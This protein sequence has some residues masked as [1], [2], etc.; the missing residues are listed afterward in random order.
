MI[1]V[2]VRMHHIIVRLILGTGIGLAPSGRGLEA[3]GSARCNEKRK[4]TTNH[5]IR[6][7]FEGTWVGSGDETECIAVRSC[8]LLVSVMSSWR[9]FLRS[10]AIY[11][12]AAI[13]FLAKKYPFALAIGPALPIAHYG[14]KARSRSRLEAPV[15]RTIEEG[16]RPTCIPSVRTIDRPV[17]EQKLKRLIY[18]DPGTI[19]DLSGS[20]MFGIVIGPSGTGKTA[21]VR[22]MCNRDPKGILYFEVFDPLCFAQDLGT[23]VGMV[24][25]PTSP[26]DLLLMFISG[27]SY[28]QYH[29]I[30]RGDLGLQYVLAG[31]EQQ[32]L[33]Y[34]ARH[35]RTPVLVVDGVDLLAK[36]NKT[37][38][39]DLIDRAKFLANS[40]SLR[41]VLVSSE[42]S[43][44]P[45]VMETSSRSR[46]ADTVEVVDISKEE[47]L[48]FIS[49]S[50]PDK[51]ARR[52]EEL[53]GG[54][55][56][57][58]LL[59][60]AKYYELQEAGEKDIEVLFKSIRNHLLQSSV[61]LSLKS[62]LKQPDNERQLYKLI[63]KQVCTKG[64]VQAQ[65]IAREFDISTER[66]E[67]A[68]DRLVSSN[69]LRFTHGGDLACY[70]RL[71]NW[72]WE[73]DL[74]DLGLPN[75]KKSK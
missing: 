16:S 58:L 57:H 37:M 9:L 62:L 59:A 65:A 29:K 47:A 36:R 61:K 56:I 74:I 38:F 20:G 23:A 17:L 67:V 7:D 46:L 54:R 10:A 49:Y 3:R 60:E 72:A 48:K 68:V 30:P 50:I 55:F 28:A 13:T 45:L 41:I 6:M 34:K 63:L 21:L 8:F 11:G 14:L 12:R 71:V 5:E 32:A 39:I 51:L 26:I 33:K 73:N 53:C 70:S 69:L 25:R 24:Q 4:R 15:L 75:P 27:E 18:P 52:I 43:V 42:G 2:L 19:E 1:V 40:H 31:L 22:R 64:E 44:L 35:G 66:I